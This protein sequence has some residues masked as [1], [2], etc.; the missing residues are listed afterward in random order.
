MRVAHDGDVLVYQA[1]WAAQPTHYDIT[2]EGS[3]VVLTTYRYKKDAKAYV[4]LQPANVRAGFLITPRQEVEPVEHV[5]QLINTI[6]ATAHSVMGAV[7]KPTVYLTSSD[8]SNFR[9][10]LA[11]IK[12]YKG[13]RTQPKP[14]HYEA[15]REFLQRRWNAQVIYGEEADDKLAQFQYDCV[16]RLYSGDAE[17]HDVT[18]IAT[19]DKD[20]DMVPG[21][22]YNYTTKQ[23][24]W[25]T[26]D[27]ALR[28]FYHQLLVGD[29]V[30]N[31]QG[32]KGI[33]KVK[34]AQALA[35]CDTEKEMYDSA[36]ALY[37]GNLPELLENAN[38][39]WMR[40]HEGEEWRPPV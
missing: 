6:M 26:Q 25:V 13:N 34:A 31:I 11:T 27:E 24:Y 19:V 17:Q 35:L 30:D 36:L 32:V 38:L 4:E 5:F 10:E 12:P 2:F 29:N 21:W 1:C 40:R 16:Q 7:G 8:K 39:L 37:K 33:G 22:H 3:D 18:C 20:L 23:R 15:A 9:Y 28:S 14:V